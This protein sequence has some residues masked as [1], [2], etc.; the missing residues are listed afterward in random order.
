MRKSRP[1]A[2][3]I[4]VEREL[5]DD[6]DAAANSADVSVHTSRLVLENAQ[7]DDFLREFFRGLPRILRADAEQDEIPLADGA[8]L[9]T[10]DGDGCLLDAREDSFHYFPAFMRLTAL[11][12]ACSEAVMISVSMPAPQVIF[13]SVPVMPM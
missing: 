1:T 12:S 6:E 3:E 13:P 2:P 11:K 5:R 7:A 9:H 8:R 4:G 10:L